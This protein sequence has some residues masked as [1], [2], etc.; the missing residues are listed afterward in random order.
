[1]HINKILISFVI[2]NSIIII[3]SYIFGFSKSLWLDELLSI[4][5]G[6]EIIGIPLREIFNID[7]HN[8]FFYSM[9]NFGQNVIKLFTLDVNGNLNYLKLI[10][11]IGFVPI[12]FSFRILKKEKTP[13]N[14][15]TV[16]LLLISS[17]Y[18]IFY[19][20][21]LRPYFLLLSFSFLI[22]VLHLT[23]TLE[24]KYKSLYLITSIIL[25]ALHVYGLTLSMSI[26]VY[27]FIL[28][29]YKKNYY[30]VKINILFSIVLFLVFIAFYFLQIT[31]KESMA[32]LKEYINIE[33]W[34]FRIFIE[35]TLNSLIYILIFLGVLFFQFKNQIFPLNSI[36]NFLKNDFVEK[37]LNLAL[38][39]LILVIVVVSLSYLVVPIIHFRPLIVIFPALALYSGV[40]SFY[41]K[42]TKKISF[43]LIIF[44]IFCTS[45]NL[46]SYLKNILYTQQN[47]EWVIKKTFT[48][49]C[50]NVDI[51]LNDKN[52]PGFIKFAKQIS[53][54]YSKYER[55]I[56]PLN[57][58]DITNHQTKYKNTKCDTL[59]FSFH[60]Y[61][62]ENF[63]ETQISKE[64]SLITEY[65]PDVVNKNSS[66]AGAIVYLSK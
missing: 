66:K 60:S 31:N 6:R 33:F 38:P 27:R 59:I 42:E 44:L 26:I 50:K 41:V 3:T 45:N 30:N 48:K 25:S 65:A 51:Y 53:E 58:I 13:I 39:A 34:Y 52:K 47:I 23:D 64:I 20:L 9:L 56:K 36:K 8:P 10:N 4:I 21:D 46:F 7:A 16:F 24:N 35:W 55:T 18:F 43:I 29:L 22:Y 63:I 61:G 37:T 54:I 11:L 12:Y 28:N 49:N 32:L 2:I 15:Y 57:E 40:I 19:I 14:F 5:F 17:N 62:L 1:M